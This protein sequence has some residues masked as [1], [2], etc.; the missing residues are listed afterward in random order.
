MNLSMLLFLGSVA[1]ISLSGVMS[2]GPVF[3][4]TVVEGRKSPLAG[5][6]VAVGHAIVEIPLILLI[7]Y[8]FAPFFQDA[9]VQKIMFLVGGSVLI[10]MGVR[11][12]RDRRGKV[13][14]AK[15]PPRHP[16]LAGVATTALNPLFIVWWATVGS[17]LIM[18]ALHFGMMGLVLFAVLHLSCDFGWLAFV[19]F[20]VHRSRKLLGGRVQSGL[21]M[22]SS[23]LLMGFGGWF[24]ASGFRTVA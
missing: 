5:V 13:K 22:A 19:S 1:L 10:W 9:L 7:N 11:L 14:I 4:A 17:M 23:L 12:F 20:M 2:P 18:K 24:M 15:G 21:I 16:V 6:K 8:G 3:A